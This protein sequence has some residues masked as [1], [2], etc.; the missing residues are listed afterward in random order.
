[1]HI[2]IE[3]G[4]FPSPKF[5]IALSRVGISPAN[6]DAVKIIEITQRRGNENIFIGSPYSFQGLIGYESNG[7]SPL[8]DEAIYRYRDSSPCIEGPSIY[9]EMVFG[10]I[11]LC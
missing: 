2:Y 11:A 8:L 10:P 1:M 5:F 7:L 9:R 6:E 4:S 3:A